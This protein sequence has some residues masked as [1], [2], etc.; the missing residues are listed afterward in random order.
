[1]E[2]EGKIVSRSWPRNRQGP[3]LCRRSPPPGSRRV[4]AA[5]GSPV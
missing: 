2:L 3:T 1:M 5:L 4:P